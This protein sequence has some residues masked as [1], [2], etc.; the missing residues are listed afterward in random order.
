MALP[1]QP[2][3]SALFLF[4]V[5]FLENC[6]LQKIKKTKSLKTWHNRSEHQPW[7][8]RFTPCLLYHLT[9]KIKRTSVW[10]VWV[11]NYK[12]KL[13]HDN[14]HHYSS[15]HNIWP[16]TLIA[17]ADSKIAQAAANGTC[18]G[19]LTHQADN[20]PAERHALDIIQAAKKNPHIQIKILDEPA[21][22]RLIGR[23][24]D[25]W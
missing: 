21:D 11:K 22:N 20:Q 24:P 23:F 14:Q 4:L 25:I 19:R 12:F 9:P 18:H 13:H 15:N 1:L 16:E 3:P 2:Y 17:V 10:E 7:P 6:I 5:L 8:R